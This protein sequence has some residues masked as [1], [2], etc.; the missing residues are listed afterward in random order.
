MNA[1]DIYP[2]DWINIVT[3]LNSL[4][5]SIFSSVFLNKYSIFKNPYVAFI[6]FFT[7]EREKSKRLINT[8]SR[9]ILSTKKGR[10]EE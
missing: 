2:F 10:E 5:A 9:M 8:K 3:D 6:L 1:N 4:Y 7:K